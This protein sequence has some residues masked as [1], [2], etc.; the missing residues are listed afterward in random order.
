MS[1]KW[2][3][4]LR[5]PCEGPWCLVMPRRSLSF[6]ARPGGL[7][8]PVG[9]PVPVLFCLFSPGGLLIP[10]KYPREI[11]WGGRKGS[12]CGGRAE[13][14]EAKAPKKT[15]H[16]L[17]SSLHRHGHLSSLHRHGFQSSQLRHGLRCLFRSGGPRPVF[18]S[19]FVLRGLQSAHPPCYGVG[20]AF[21]EG[22]V[23][24]GFCCVCH[25]FLPHVSIFG[26]FP[27]LVK[28]HY[29]LILVQPC[30]SNYLWFTCVFIVL[31]VQFDFVWSTRYFP[32]VCCLWVLPGPALSYLDVIKDYYLSLSPR[33]HVP[34]SSLVC[35]P[36]HGHRNHQELPKKHSEYRSNCI[37][38]KRI[39]FF[40]QGCIK[41]TE[42]SSP[43]FFFSF[44]FFWQIYSVYIYIYIYI[45]IFTV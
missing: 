40:Q 18:L 26:L 28:C 44:L 31:S 1:W 9:C 8:V 15:R 12:G 14:T 23:M 41:Q 39:L 32:G 19:V 34:V 22:G 29:E 24:S 37:A 16:G 7:P 4:K 17:L 6:L 35:A 36:W 27:V 33:L 42:R 2:K 25:L 3:R 13:R 21:R 20:H 43:K 11:F 5:E 38:K 45:Y 30:L 10:P